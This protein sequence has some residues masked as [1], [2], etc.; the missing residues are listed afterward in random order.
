MSSV[1]D[2]KVIYRE[3]NDGNRQNNNIIQRLIMEDY[4]DRFKKVWFY[5][6]I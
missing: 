3:I 2:S 6:K 4:N 1:I 5:R